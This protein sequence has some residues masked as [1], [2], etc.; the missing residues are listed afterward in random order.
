V[1]FVVLCAFGLTSTPGSANEID[2]NWINLFSIAQQK[3]VLSSFCVFG[4]FGELEIMLVS[5][6]VFLMIQ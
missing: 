6:E 4:W 3:L 5:H 2:G 1:C